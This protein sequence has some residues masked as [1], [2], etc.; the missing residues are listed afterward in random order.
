MFIISNVHSKS[1]INKEKSFTIIQP[2]GL[3]EAIAQFRKNNIPFLYFSFV[4]V[5][6]SMFI[7]YLLVILSPDNHNPKPLQ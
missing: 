1:S 6:S 3:C 7:L 5:M 2:M 4:R